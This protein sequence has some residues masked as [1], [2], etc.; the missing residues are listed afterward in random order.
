MAFETWRELAS[1]GPMLTTLDTLTEQQIRTVEAAAHAVGDHLQ[2]DMCEYALGGDL[3]A[4]QQVLG[5][6]NTVEKSRVS[7]W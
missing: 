6:I 5:F 4:R 2:C 7:Q 1:A 3:L